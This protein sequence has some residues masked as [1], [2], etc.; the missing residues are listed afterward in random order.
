MRRPNATQRTPGQPKAR[1]R[2]LA[3]LALEKG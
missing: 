1:E 2:V 3:A